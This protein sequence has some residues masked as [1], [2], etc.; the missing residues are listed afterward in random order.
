MATA[1]CC[2]YACSSAL[3]SSS[4]RPFST[5]P[6]PTSA[7]HRPTAKAAAAAKATATSPIQPTP[8]SAVRTARLAAAAAAAAAAG[9]S[10]VARATGSE[11]AAGPSPSELV[12]PRLIFD[13]PRHITY[14]Q[15]QV[16]STRMSLAND[17]G[18]VL[19]RTSLKGA[20]SNATFRVSV[21]RK[22]FLPPKGSAPGA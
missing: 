22:E 4:R 21:A 18:S 9:T 7:F 11:D 12:G 14:P 8:L 5:T 13:Q 16:Q 20:F 10:D 6:F 1:R 19:R 17:Q 15:N 2:S 3:A